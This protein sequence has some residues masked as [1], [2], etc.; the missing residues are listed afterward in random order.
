M[1]S[2]RLSSI[3]CLLPPPAPFDPKARRY[4]AGECLR[5]NAGARERPGHIS[6]VT[7][8]R[9]QRQN[10]RGPGIGPPSPSTLRGVFFDLGSAITVLVDRAVIISR[11]SLGIL[12]LVFSPY[13]AQDH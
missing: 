6:S 8:G 2:K 4:H 10:S 9:P 11:A 5:L 1:V 7:F 12:A 3:L 13:S